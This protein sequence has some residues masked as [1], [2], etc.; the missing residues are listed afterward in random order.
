[1]MRAGSARQCVC[2][3]RGTAEH[4]DDRHYLAA[5]TGCS[6]PRG[7]RGPRGAPRHRANW[8][9]ACTTGVVGALRNKPLVHTTRHC[10]DSVAPVG[11]DYGGGRGGETSKDNPAFENSGAQTII[12]KY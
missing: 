6:C 4:R 9:A 2:S 1:M 5:G 3:P 11:R 7:P 10:A 12:P 8:S